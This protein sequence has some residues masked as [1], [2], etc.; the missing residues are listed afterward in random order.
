MEIVVGNGGDDGDGNDDDDG[1]LNGC[2]VG[3]KRNF[4]C[5]SECVV[6][7]PNWDPGPNGLAVELGNVA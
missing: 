5:V 1:C 6:T 3:I 4:V 2:L 7:Y